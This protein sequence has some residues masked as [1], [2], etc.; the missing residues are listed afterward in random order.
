MVI[1]LGTLIA[2]GDSHIPYRADKIPDEFIKFIKNMDLDK[3]ICTGDLVR[4]DV[5][6]TFEWISNKLVIVRGNMD[7]G[8][9]ERHPL[10]QSFRYEGLNFLVYHGHRVYPRGD[11]EKLYKISKKRGAEVLITG[12]THTPTIRKFRDLL[13][14]NPGSIC[15]VWGGAGG[16]GR[17]T[18][19][20]INVS[21]R[22]VKVKIYEIAGGGIVLHDEAD[23]EL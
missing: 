10:F 18:W 12:H 20:L 15:G 5:L 23:F 9:A 7:E 2:W 1:F 4:I 13:I 21:E 8:D 19:G 14:I 22:R 17:P 3:L 11:P 6:K 16:Y